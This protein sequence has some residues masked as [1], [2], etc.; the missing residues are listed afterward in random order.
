[1]LNNH[2]V[3]TKQLTESTC[4]EKNN[5][6]MRSYEIQCGEISPEFLC[7]MKSIHLSVHQL[8]PLIP[9]DTGQGAGYTLDRPNKFILYKEAIIFLEFIQDKAINKF[10]MEILNPEKAEWK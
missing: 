3:P 1:M 4:Q 5:L 10:R 7:A 9:A 2:H 8:Y 6:N